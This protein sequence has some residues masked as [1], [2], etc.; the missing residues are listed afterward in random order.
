MKDGNSSLNVRLLAIVVACMLVIGMVIF[1]V[2]RLQV[3]RQAGLYLDQAHSTREAA[4]K[5]EDLDEKLELL[6]KAA[7]NYQRYEGAARIDARQKNDVVAENGLMLVDAAQTYSEAGRDNDATLLYGKAWGCLEKVLREEPQRKQLRR[8]LIQSLYELGQGAKALD[9]MAWFAALPPDADALRSLFDRYDLWQRAAATSSFGSGGQRDEIL[10]DFLESDGKKT[11]SER[12][13]SWLKDNDLLWTVLEDPDLLSIFAKCQIQLNRG[14]LAEKPLEKTILL[15]PRRLE[16]YRLLAELLR[17]FNREKDADYWMTELI[18]ANPGSHEAMRLRGEYREAS[19]QRS[20]ASDAPALA[21]AALLD[22]VR[23]IDQALEQAVDKADAAAPASPLLKDLKTAFEEARAQQP[24][25]GENPTPDYRDQLT[26]AVKKLKLLGEKVPKTAKEVEGARDGLLLAAQCELAAARVDPQTTP[27]PHLANAQAY[28]RAT[29]ELFPSHAPAYLVLAEVEQR[30]GNQQQ[31]VEWLRRGSKF[32]DARALVMWRLANLLI[33]I[34]RLKEARQAIDEMEK[35]GAADVFLEQLRAM[36]HHAEGNWLA[37]KEG[38]ERALPQLQAWPESAL[39][40]NQLIADCCEKL[41]LVDQQR[42]ALLRSIALDSTSMD[43]L[44]NLAQL[45]MESGQFAEAA[46]DY[47]SVLR[48]RTAPPGAHL[49]LVRALLS[50]NLSLPRIERNWL[51]VETAMEQAEKRLPNS[52]R[53]ALL[54]AELLTARDKPREATALLIELRMQLQQDIARLNEKRDAAQKEAE[55]LADAE[56]KRKLDEAKRLEQMISASADLQASIWQSLVHLAERQEDWASAAKLIDAAENESG[57]TPRIRVLKARNLANQNGADA[58][59][60]IKELLQGSEKLPPNQQAWLCRNFAA[61]NHGIGDYRAAGELCDRSLTLE[62]DNLES[63]RLRFQIAASQSDAAAMQKSLNEIKRIEKKPGAF[64][65]YG[66]AMRI[67]KTVE[68]GGDQKILQKGLDHLNT[69]A[70]MR[71]RWG[72]VNLLAGAIRERMGNTNEAV[73][74]Y[75]KAVDLGV[76][77][78]TVVRRTAQLLLR[79]NRLREADR[80]FRL[81]AE[82][83]PLLSDDATREMRWVRARLGEFSAAIESARKVAASSGDVADSIWLGQLLSVESQ[84]LRKQERQEEADALTKEAEEAF[85]HAVILKSD[86]P[87]PWVALIQFLVQT[88][89][90]EKAEKTVVQAQR[91]LPK[92]V[93]ATALGQ[94]YEILGKTDKAREQYEAALANAPRDPNVVETV[95]SFYYRTNQFAQVESLLMRIIRGEVNAN[96]EQQMEARRRIATILTQQ[97]GETNRETAVKWVDKNL[98]EDPN[99]TSDRYLKAVILAQDVSGKHKQEAISSL[100]KLVAMKSL[101]D[102]R[103]QFTL[104]QLYLEEGNWRGYRLQMDELL[105]TYRDVPRY[106]AAYAV[107]LMDRKEYHE[108][109]A[110]AAE[111]ARL[112]PNHPLTVAVRSELAFQQRQYERARNLLHDYLDDAAATPAEK[113]D[114]LR[115]VAERLQ[116]LAKRLRENQENSWADIFA[117]DAH[118][119]YRRYVD[120][121]PGEDL[122]MASFM[123]RQRRLNEAI[124]LV[125]TLWEASDP[126]QTARACFDI[127]DGTGAS[128]EQVSRVD[129]ILQESAKRDPGA[130]VLK[131]VIA[132]LR[133]IQERY[134]EAEAVYREI[135]K[136][137]PNNPTA[138]N[139]LAVLLARQGVKLNEASEMID[140]AI[141]DTRPSGTLLD[142]RAMV[143]LALNRPDAALEDLQKAIAEEPTAMRFFHQAEAF[144]ARGQ[145]KAAIDALNRAVKMGLHE[146]QL[147]GSERRKFKKLQV[148]LR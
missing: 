131:I 60:K 7:A 71:P 72:H 130:L 79:N 94:C 116:G 29:V 33:H 10:A 109:E 32:K 111:L 67:L 78:P 76:T 44:L 19:V 134:D 3:R 145:R 69:A 41:G 121:R 127:I 85:R 20:K 142:T 75:L 8:T 86:A 101:A 135:L 50:K 18:S 144:H 96:K 110:K 15:A 61:I 24:A 74:E 59:P 99:S 113:R 141:K 39:R 123:A 138:L 56:K 92:E 62:P 117:Q 107:A 11:N 129:R 100:E 90:N 6:L 12:V 34:G 27:S 120:L 88:G 112:A 22:A 31:A 132:E 49:G 148:L 133:S 9:H 17:S 73:D 38:F 139:N 48:Q 21:R 84:R 124:D 42:A 45:E 95:A 137:Y 104:A 51:E 128:P 65:H 55:T 23:S 13:L 103:M 57:D 118:Q 5:T 54:R 105:K 98:K 70:Q 37:A 68:Q 146:E 143:H 80:M 14:E 125:D 87:E 114:R 126:E 136:K 26:N 47:R 58:A 83:E 40:T 36:V 115:D 64:W 93:A 63:Q 97:G 4:D 1:V 91:K 108:A 122:L 53:V 119:T 82:R 66:E 16:N 89:Q 2:H 77:E 46:E 81:L 25:E 30:L 140:R 106:V 147:Q 35:E 43:V 28:G 102:P 52:P